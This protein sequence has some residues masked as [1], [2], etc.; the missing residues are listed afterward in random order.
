MIST[1]FCYGCSRW[2]GE[3][4]LPLGS[5]IYLIWQLLRRLLVGQ[6]LA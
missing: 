5:G 1:E 3:P 2:K 6:F 4:A